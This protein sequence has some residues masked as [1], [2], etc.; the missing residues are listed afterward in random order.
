MNMQQL[1]FGHQSTAADLGTTEPLRE[2]QY[3]QIC[4]SVVS[5]LP[6]ACLL[7]SYDL[8]AVVSLPQIHGSKMAQDQSAGF[9]AIRARG[10]IACPSDHVIEGY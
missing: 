9:S 7:V 10:L 4:L 6:G 2:L 3:H 8:R 5:C 1:C